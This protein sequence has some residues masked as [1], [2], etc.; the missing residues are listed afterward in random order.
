MGKSVIEALI[1]KLEKISMEVPVMISKAF[2][3]EEWVSKYYSMDTQTR[4]LKVARYPIPI[5][6]DCSTI[7]ET[8]LRLLPHIDIGGISLLYPDGSASGGLQIV[9]NDDWVNV[10]GK[11][12]HL[13]CGAG[14]MISIATNGRA[15]ATK[16]RVVMPS[17]EEKAKSE[18]CSLIYFLN[19]SVETPMDPNDESPE[20]FGDFLDKSF[21]NCLP[22]QKQGN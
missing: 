13:I 4:L 15:I 10:P 7:S 21:V 6:G 22:K 2:G 9:L 5:D 12:N 8:K 18:R 14:N 3:I 16:H 11:Q 19:P 1:K 20:L 17:I